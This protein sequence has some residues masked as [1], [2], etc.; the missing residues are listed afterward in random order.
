MDKRDVHISKSLSYLLRHGALKEN[1]LVDNNGYVPVIQLLSHNRLKTHKTTIQDLERVV[2]N[3]DKQRFKFNEAHDML[4]A[5]QGHSIEITPD[6]T[7]LTPIKNLE[8]LPNALIHG[9]NLKNLGLILESGGIK[10][11][12]RLHIHLSPGI[13][14][15]D[16]E[17]ISG[18]RKNSTVLIY[19]RLGDDLIKNLHLYKSLNNVYL[20]SDTI[21]LKDFDR[22]VIRKVTN[23]EA[24]YGKTLELLNK[25]EITYQIE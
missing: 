24:K 5:V 6:S 9:T 15:V 4:A 19:L 23:L 8:Q 1:L 2:A 10:K 22:I 12:D 7:T 17:V 18:M 25:F 14:G 16:K 20:C 13:V 3:N 11:M 21:P